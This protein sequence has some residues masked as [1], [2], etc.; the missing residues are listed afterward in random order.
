[1]LY[2]TFFSTL[3]TLFIYT[4]ASV[5]IKQYGF[6]FFAVGLSLICPTAFF[7]KTRWYKSNVSYLKQPTTN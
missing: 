6:S 2:R 5:L 3:Q 7:R 4:M 1:C